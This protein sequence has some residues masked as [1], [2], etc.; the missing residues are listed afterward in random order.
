VRG[1]SIRLA[2]ARDAER[3]HGALRLLSEELGDPHRAGVDDLVRAGFGPEPAFHAVL[4]E[5]GID[6]YGIC[7]FSPVFSALRGGVGAYVSDLWVAP[8]GRSMGLGRLLLDSAQSEAAQRWEARF[9]RLMV[10]NDNPRA[11]SFYERIG[12]SPSQ[13]ETVLTIEYTNFGGGS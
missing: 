5:R 13:G 6:L 12:F 4:A 7:M 8:E 3:L 2:E 10:N 9:L 1:A 11:R